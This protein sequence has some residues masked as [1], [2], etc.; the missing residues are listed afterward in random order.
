MGPG[1]STR[2]D[3]AIVGCGPAIERQHSQLVDF[4]KEDSQNAMWWIFKVVVLKQFQL[5][6]DLDVLF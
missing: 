5:E 6:H 3:E 1:S 4:L 2:G